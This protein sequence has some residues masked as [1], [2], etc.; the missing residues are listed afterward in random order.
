VTTGSGCEQRRESRL[1]EGEKETSDLSAVARAGLNAA[2]DS[3]V[4]RGQARIWGVNIMSGVSG[5]F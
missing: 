3:M 1:V 4:A 2:G 5:V